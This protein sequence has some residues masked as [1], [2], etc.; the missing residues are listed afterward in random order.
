MD[1]KKI[2]PGLSETDPE[3]AQIFTIFA[4]GEVLDTTEPLAR[5]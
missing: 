2:F 3:F 5:R 1:T 4:F